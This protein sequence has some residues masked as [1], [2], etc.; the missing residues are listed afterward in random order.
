MLDVGPASYRDVRHLKSRAAREGV[1]IT[2]TTG[3]E[4]IAARTRAGRV[5]G[6]A[7]VIRQGPK[8]RVKGVYLHPMFRGEGTGRRLMDTA[9]GIA[10]RSDADTLEVLARFADGWLRYDLEAVSV[11]PNGAVTLR[12]KLDAPPP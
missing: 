2:D 3:T 6:C 8:V 4:W 1:A 9:V 11:R 12:G 10:R 7:A 5:V